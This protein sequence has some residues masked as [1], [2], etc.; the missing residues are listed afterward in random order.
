MGVI[1]FLL[2]WL[3]IVAYLLVGRWLGKASR[4]AWS[5]AQNARVQ[6]YHFAELVGPLPTL[7]YVF[8]PMTAVSRH[9][10][11]CVAE[12]MLDRDKLDADLTG[13][14]LTYVRAHMLFWPL[15]V[16]AML[17]TGCIS[18]Y[19]FTLELRTPKKRI[20]DLQKRRDRIKRRLDTLHTRLHDVDAELDEL[21]D[22][23][24]RELVKLKQ[25]VAHDFD[26]PPRPSP[27]RGRAAVR[28]T[29]APRRAPPT[30]KRFLN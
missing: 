4:R 12:F 14:D 19:T 3:P 2:A 16:V 13:D 21:V 26:A 22:L 6:R 10:W 29:L 17:I 1:N 9:I 30:D 28:P 25:D 23:Q 11:P 27:E 18:L 15:R 5:Q 24:A 8:F 7:F 20:H